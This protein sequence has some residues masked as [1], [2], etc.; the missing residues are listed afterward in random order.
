MSNPSGKSEVPG[1]RA[2]LGS[3]LVAF[4]ANGLVSRLMASTASGPESTVAPSG[5][6]SIENFSAAGASLGTVRAAK[7]IKSDAEWRA[8]R[9]TRPDLA[10]ARDGQG[11]W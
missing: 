3:C 8:Q 10:A 4:A 2:F 6:V 1:R 7:V 5:E 9:F 11:E